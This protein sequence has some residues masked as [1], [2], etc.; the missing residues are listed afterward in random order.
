MEWRKTIETVLIIAILIGLY[1]YQ[2]PISISYQEVL[3]DLIGE[4]ETVE[5]IA[6]YTGSDLSN[7]KA[8]YIIEEPYLLNRFMKLDTRLKQRKGKHPKLLINALII[9]TNK[10]SYVVGIDTFSFTIG[11]REYSTGGIM[12]PAYVLI[13]EKNFEWEIGEYSYVDSEL[14]EEYPIFAK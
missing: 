5:K 8:T 3:S 13:K 11:E 7:Q 6:V 4:D 10:D 14:G 2:R 1:L 9:K 12:N